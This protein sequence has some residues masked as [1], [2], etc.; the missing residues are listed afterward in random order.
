MAAS[1]PWDRVHIDYGEWKN[2][3]FLVLVD[4]FC[5]WPEVKVMSTT[6]TRM[7]VNTFLRLTDI[8]ESLFRTMVRNS[9]LLNLQIFS[10]RT[11]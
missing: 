9:P 7:I 10:S 5:K 2:H 11:T 6:T 1:A 8:L 4:A 3:H